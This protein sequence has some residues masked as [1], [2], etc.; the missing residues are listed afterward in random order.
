MYSQKSKMEKLKKTFEDYGF[1]DFELLCKEFD[2]L[3]IEF[4]K[5]DFLNSFVRIVINRSRRFGDYVTPFFIP[6]GFYAS[7]IQGHVKEKEIII[8]AK[9]LYKELMINYHEGLKVE[10]GSEKEQLKYLKDYIKNYFVLKKRVLKL[11]DTCQ[12]VF[13]NLEEKK[14]E[15][16]YLG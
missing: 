5:M 11:L 9:D 12:D 14:D 10:F 6:S 7:I 3:S 4:E 2:L 8:E 16:G 1:E 15:K 13:K